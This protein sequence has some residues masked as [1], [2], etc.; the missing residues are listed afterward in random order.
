[1]PNPNTPADLVR[2]V[3]VGVGHLVSGGLDDQQRAVLLDELSGYYGE[4]TDVRHPFS[5]LGDT[6][7][8]TRRELYDHFAAIP[9]RAAGEIDFAPSDMTAHQTADPE[10]V[11]AEFS[12]RGSVAGRPFEL[13]CIFV[14]RVRDGEIVESRDYAHHIENA[15]VFGRLGDLAAALADQT[16]HS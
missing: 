12:Y 14:V 9:K 5:P 4:R 13:P 6:P 3:T 15:R 2:A 1:M 11:I 8:R 7:L 16:A 10:V